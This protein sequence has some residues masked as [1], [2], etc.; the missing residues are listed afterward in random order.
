MEGNKLFKSDKAVTVCIILPEG[1]FNPYIPSNLINFSIFFHKRTNVTNFSKKRR[2]NV[3]FKEILLVEIELIENL[4]D[5]FP[6]LV[7]K[8]F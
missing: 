7:V 6:I 4:E 3:E 8:F 1:L 5:I 2:D